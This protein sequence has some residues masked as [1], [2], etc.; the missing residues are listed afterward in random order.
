MPMHTPYQFTFQKTHLQTGL[1]DGT[2]E[3]P[4]DT[5]SLSKARMQACEPQAMLSLYHAKSCHGLE[6][7]A[8]LKMPACLTLA[9]RGVL[10]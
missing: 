10:Q 9:C 1:K 8:K 4:C 7:A 2:L 5:D 6:D 3:S